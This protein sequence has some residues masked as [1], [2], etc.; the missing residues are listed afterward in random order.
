MASFQAVQLNQYRNW[1]FLGLGCLRE[2]RDNV[3]T[4]APAVPLGVAVNIVVER[5]NAKGV[6]TSGVKPS[7]PRIEF[8][9][10]DFPDPVSPVTAIRTTF[11]YPTS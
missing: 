3:G 2:L 7:S 4:G 11:S 8:T 9:V 10:A 6:L 1:H 5:K